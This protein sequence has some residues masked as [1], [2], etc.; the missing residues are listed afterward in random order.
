MSFLKSCHSGNSRAR[1]STH[2]IR[3]LKISAMNQ[4][5]VAAVLT[6]VLRHLLAIGQDL[7][8]HIRMFVTEVTLKIPCTPHSQT[9]KTIGR[10]VAASASRIVV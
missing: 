6:N 8:E 1:N 4:N 5:C 2:E 7:L 3:H 10:L 9:E